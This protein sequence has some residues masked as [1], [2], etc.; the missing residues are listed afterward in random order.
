MN[1]C[2]EEEE[3]WNSGQPILGE[4]NLSLSYIW[5]WWYNKE[6]KHDSTPTD[7]SWIGFIAVAQ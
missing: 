6:Q 3:S 7:E 5:D 1:R 2:V 4:N